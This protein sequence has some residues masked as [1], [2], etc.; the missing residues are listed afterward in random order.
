MQN[1]YKSLGV[2]SETIDNADSS[3]L[4]TI[5]RLAY[6]YNNEVKDKSFVGANNVE[7]DPYDAL[8]YKWMGKNTELKDHTATPELNTYIQNVK[9]YQDNYNM[10][11]LRALGGNL[12][13]YGSWMDTLTDYNYGDNDLNWNFNKWMNPWSNPIWE[14][15]KPG[16]TKNHYVP[17]DIS[18]DQVIEA[19]NQKD[20]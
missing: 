16:N 8:M 19:E 18:R 17:V 20:Y 15:T 6:M 4:A 12:Y 11:T 3:A 7:M 5:A 1:I 9:K 13:P 10:Y 14:Y 2:T